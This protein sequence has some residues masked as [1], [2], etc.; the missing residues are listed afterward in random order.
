MKETKPIVKV[1]VFHNGLKMLYD[2]RFIYTDQSFEWFR[3]HCSGA[4]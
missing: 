2:C 4:Q 1:I 3:L